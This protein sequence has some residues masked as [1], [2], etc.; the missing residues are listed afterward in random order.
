MVNTS[1]SIAKAM[2]KDVKFEL[3]REENN[4][5]I[6]NIEAI[7]VT[8]TGN[9]R[10]YT[11]EE[12]TLGARSLS[13]RPININHDRSRWLEYN[14][15]DPTLANTTLNLDFDGTKNGVA[16]QIQI[17][18]TKVN[19]AIEA[20]NINKVSIE[21]LPSKGESCSCALDGCTCEQHGIVF[22]G[23]ALLEKEVKPGDSTTKIIKPESVADEP[24]VLNDEILH[25][26]LHSLGIEDQAMSDCMSEV[27]SAHPGMK[28][29]QMVA[30]CMSKLGRSECACPT[31]QEL[32]R[33]NELLS[34]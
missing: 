9:K 17:V 23:I 20:G 19:E 29:D 6:W 12:L 3:V 32:K 13:Y 18:D 4:A 28:Q 26:F 16:G 7:H 10:K 2:R 14:P 5:K 8:V 1:E 27:H 30:I 15:F 24:R 22:T 31:M 25:K 33:L 34:A 21:Q 11:K